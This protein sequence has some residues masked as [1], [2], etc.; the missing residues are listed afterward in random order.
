M[1]MDMMMNMWYAIVNQLNHSN[2]CQLFFIYFFMSF[3]FFFTYSYLQFAQLIKFSFITQG[4]I[5]LFSACVL[6]L[7]LVAY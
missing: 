7:I 6:H 1:M 3:L 5:V 2:R 4:F